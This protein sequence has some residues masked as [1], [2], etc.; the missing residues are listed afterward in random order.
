MGDYPQLDPALITSHAVSIEQIQLGSL[1]L[2]AVAVILMIC[3]WL[4]MNNHFKLR[5]ESL[6]MRHFI[7]D[8]SLSRCLTAL[9]AA[10]SQLRSA[11]QRL[12]KALIEHMHKRHDADAALSQSS[13][14]SATDDFCKCY[15]S[16]QIAVRNLK[17]LGKDVTDMIEKGRLLEKELAEIFEP[18]KRQKKYLV[19]AQEQNARLHALA[20]PLYDH[21]QEY[22]WSLIDAK[23]DL[24][25]A[26]DMSDVDWLAFRFI[27][28]HSR[29]KKQAE[30]FAVK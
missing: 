27:S 8:S 6:F 11:R 7:A 30:Q 26:G 21:V 28:L 4:R 23:L 1:A 12:E 9:R 16:M 25:Y 20:Q 2:A 19:S 10:E 22:E 15:L 13:L 14:D 3:G 18:S 17:E 29:L 5:L 24:H